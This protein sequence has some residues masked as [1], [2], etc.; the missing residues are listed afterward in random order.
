MRKKYLNIEPQETKLSASPRMLSRIRHTAYATQLLGRVLRRSD[1]DHSSDP[2]RRCR[3]C[4]C[5]HRPLQ[6]RD[7]LHPRRDPCRRDQPEAHHPGF[8]ASEQR[9]HPCLQ[10]GCSLLRSVHPGGYGHRHQECL[11][12]QVR[13]SQCRQPEGLLQ[14][15]LRKHR[16]R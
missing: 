16:Y 14:V 8:R 2:L 13:R 4:G 11:R 7:D 5:D 10:Q 6:L 9:Y 1:H 15:L 3:S 12:Q